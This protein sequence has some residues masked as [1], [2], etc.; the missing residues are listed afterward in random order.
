METDPGRPENPRRL[1]GRRQRAAAGLSGHG[2]VILIVNFFVTC[3]PAAS[4]IVIEPLKVP[5]FVGEP[6]NWMVLPTRINFIPG[7]APLGLPAMAYCAV[8]PPM[9]IVPL[10]PGVF[11]VHVVTVK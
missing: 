11:L 5:T 7:G 3:T 6:V 1:P 4:L 10:K 2:C 9:V 8:P